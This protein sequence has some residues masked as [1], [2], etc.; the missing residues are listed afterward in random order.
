MGR[1]QAVNDKQK[2]FC[3]EYLVDNNA[4]KALIRAGYSEKGAGVAANK[5]LKKPLVREYL[6]QL[7]GELLTG[8]EKIINDNIN[9]WVSM[10]DTSEVEL[11]DGSSRQI[12]PSDRLKASELLGKHLG[13][14]T[15]KIE[16]S[17]KD[18]KPLEISVI[19]R[20]IVDKGT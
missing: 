6:E 3:R 12:Y 17:G 4:T 2:A 10:R 18:G 15:E 8:R 20:V 1:K 16:H 5:L 13:M 9:F 14:F 19:K 11:E 7:R